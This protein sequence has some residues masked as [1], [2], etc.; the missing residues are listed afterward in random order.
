MPSNQAVNTFVHISAASHSPPHTLCCYKAEAEALGERAGSW[1]RPGGSW[2]SSA[3]PF[4]PR[5]LQK[6]LICSAE[7]SHIN[8]TVNYAGNNAGLS[9]DHD[10]G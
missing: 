5:S 10:L 9:S 4:F 6:Q 1:M 3:F 2:L 8:A 7:A